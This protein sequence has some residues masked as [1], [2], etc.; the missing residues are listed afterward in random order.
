MESDSPKQTPL[1]SLLKS[2]G[3]TFTPFAGYDMP[4]QFEAG[5]KTEHE[6]TR[7]KAGLFDVSHMGPC[8][9]SLTSGLGTDGAHE[10]ISAIIEKVVPSDIAALKPGQARLTVL[11]NSKGGIVDD[12]IVT[13]PSEPE[14]AGQLYIVVNGAT[15][16]ND[17]RILSGLDEG[18]T[19]Q[20]VENACLVA[21][22]GPM[23]ENVLS[24]HLS[25]AGTLSFMTSADFEQDGHVIKVS[26]CGYT[27]EDGFELLM[28]AELGPTFVEKL[29][30]D[31][32]V[33]PI[34]LGARNSL[35][36]EAGLCLYG[37]DI[38][39]TTTPVE[40]SLAWLVSK[41]R[42]ETKDFAGAAIIL[43]QL[44][45][46]PSKKRVGIQPQGR[47]PAR[48]GTPIEIDGQNVGEITSGCFGPTVNAPVAMG[49]VSANFAE[50]GTEL[51]LIIRGKK[52]PARVCE[53][54]FIP[55]KYKR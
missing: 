43:D 36:L 9:L 17:F 54:P 7:T 16:D 18:A 46:G 4:L 20:V 19:L 29:L 14:L 47:A 2:H 3:A 32:R 51:D 55:L 52:H 26:R 42:R 21:L 39:E 27:G 50:I 25:E 38:D 31:E 35:R 53:L 8:F 23:A 34:G 49:Y 13:R 37:N 28:D 24:D 11:L 41:R 5:V 22:Q 6:W 30:R 10:A 45:N 33:L 48:D 15:K 1:H 40:G 44:R 12:L